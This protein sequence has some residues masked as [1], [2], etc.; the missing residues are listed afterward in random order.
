M[1][2]IVCSKNKLLNFS[3]NIQGQCMYMYTSMFSAV[4]IVV[5]AVV[6]AVAF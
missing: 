6:A 5:V 2:T 1:L 4:L 3:V